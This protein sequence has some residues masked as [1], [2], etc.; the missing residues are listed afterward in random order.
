[1]NETRVGCLGLMER[2]G[3]ALLLRGAG[4]GLW[5]RRRSAAS[6]LALHLAGRLGR[7]AELAAVAQLVTRVSGAA[8]RH[9]WDAHPDC[10]KGKGEGSWAAMSVG[11]AHALSPNR[12]A[13][14]LP[15]PHITKLTP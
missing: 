2:P 15:P 1:M 12:P 3:A 5:R 6:R 13:F 11:T 7:V 8:D 4:V 14:P 10:R 9:C